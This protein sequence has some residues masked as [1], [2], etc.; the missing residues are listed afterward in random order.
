MATRLVVLLRGINVGG[1]KP[2]DMA[3]LRGM[4]G[5]LGFAEV[6]TLL[7]SGNAVVTA[8]PRQVTGAAAQIEDA[9]AAKFAI[10]CR[11]VVRTA[12]GLAAAMAADP[13]LPVVDNPSRHLV[14]FLSDPPD[15]SG[16]TQLTA[17]DYGIDQLRVVDQHVYLWCPNGITG[18]PLGKLNLDRILNAA[19][20]MRNWNTVTKL[21]ARAGV[22]P[23]PVAR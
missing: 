23:Q 22:R 16:V 3:R 14:G 12:T 20:T 15:K 1:N 11:V 2:V 18:S 6:E 13:L 8:T 19:V 4:L 7:Q 5:N 21:A 9:I 10:E 17:G